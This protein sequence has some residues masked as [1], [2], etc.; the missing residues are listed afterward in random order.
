MANL[1]T[2]FYEG[3]NAAS[4]SLVDSIPGWMFWSGSKTLSSSVPTTT[5][6]G[7]VGLEAILNSCVVLSF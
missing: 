1:R 6:Y 2:N 7:G 3:F 4:Q 5:V